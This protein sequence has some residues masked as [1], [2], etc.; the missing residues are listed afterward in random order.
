MRKRFRIILLVMVMGFSTFILFAW[1]RQHFVANSL[2][3]MPLDSPA[4][5]HPDHI[6]FVWLENK[7][8]DNIIGNP[9]APFINSLVKMG[10]LFTNSHANTHPSYPNYLDFF[11][12]DDNG[13]KDDACIDNS[14]LTTPNLYTILKTAGKTFAWYSE[15]LP[16]T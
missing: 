16:K 11:A 2:S 1:S 13:V 3:A 8:F 6:I 10:T 5:A 9:D 4:I 15:D 12:G 14:S 7:D